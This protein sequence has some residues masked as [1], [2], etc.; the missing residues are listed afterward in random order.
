MANYQAARALMDKGRNAGEG[1]AGLSKSSAKEGRQ[2]LRGKKGETAEVTLATASSEHDLVPPT[3]CELRHPAR[4]RLR[5]VKENR[6][7]LPNVRSATESQDSS[8]LRRPGPGW[9]Y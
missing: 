4:H 9:P 3:I 8:S 6:P 5:S 2:E 1:A 7:G